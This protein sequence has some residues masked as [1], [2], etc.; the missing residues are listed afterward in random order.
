MAL[1][2]PLGARACEVRTEV[3]MEAAP[4]RRPR[5]GD[6]PVSVTSGRRV[7]LRSVLLGLNGSIPGS[8]NRQFGMESSIDP[9]KA[10]PGLVASRLLPS[11]EHAQA[12]PCGVVA[13]GGGRAWRVAASPIPARPCMCM[14]ECY[15]NRV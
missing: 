15:L 8:K 1:G 12:R 11:L 13:D 4:M 6:E 3:A 10:G 2:P 5:G 7:V 9:A 14:P